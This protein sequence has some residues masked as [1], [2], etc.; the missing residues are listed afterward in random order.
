MSFKKENGV[1]VATQNTKLPRHLKYL[2]G[3]ITNKG[4]RD[5]MTGMLVQATM[6]SFDVVTGKK[7]EPKK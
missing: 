7:Q 1:Y 5:H 6:A 4:Q 2:L 3:T